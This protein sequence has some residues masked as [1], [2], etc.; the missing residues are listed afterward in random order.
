ML[1][2]T[3]ARMSTAEFFLAFAAIL[4]SARVAAEI[5]TRFGA[6][7][8][9]GELTAGIVLGPSVLGWIEPTEVIRLMAEIGIILLLFEV[10]LETDLGRLAKAGKKSIT[11]A[12]GGF[13]V[14]FVLGYATARYLFDAE[15]I[16]AMFIGGTLTATSI[17]ITVRILRDVGRQTSR[18]G[19]IVL[20]AAVIDDLLGVLLLAV[21][22]E[23]S[24]T[25]MLG[26]ANIGKLALFIGIFFFVA[27]IAAKL[28]SYIVG[29]YHQATQ[30]PGLITT[31][32]VSLVLLFAWFAHAIGA[33][34][35]IGG[36]AAGLALSRRF[37]LPFGAALARDQAF[38]GEVERD[39]KPII[40]LFTPV[41]FVTVG[42]QLDLREV[43]WTSSFIWYFSFA[44]GFVAII[45][46]IAGGYLMRGEHWLMRS[47][48]GMAM[49]PR[50]EV[51]LIFAELGRA[52]GIFD[53]AMYAAVVLVIAY[54]TLFS[55]FW[56]KLFYRL[57]GGHVALQESADTPDKPA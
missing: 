22:Y 28:V 48:V 12:I 21:L 35:I 29:H 18:E 13:I 45:G 36:F 41:F 37:F 33:P 52:A 5:A 8:V 7:S 27:P 43:E 19:Q 38:A 11:V 34:E 46:K 2:A 40:Q 1:R 56:I 47:A 14:P 53:A 3:I 9:I 31:S 26:L 54:T 55:P 20:G 23:L 39:M 16:V 30:V 42:L 57:F 15:N 4:V 24:R 32:I 44:V 51:G 6:P 10:G 17:G 49:V 50:G 25:G